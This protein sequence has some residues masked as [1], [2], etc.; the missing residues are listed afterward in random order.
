M[1]KHSAKKTQEIMT[2]VLEEVNKI[3]EKKL[4]GL[5]VVSVKLQPAAASK[6]TLAAND[7]GCTFQLVCKPIPGGMDCK[8][9]CV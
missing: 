4:P 5:S 6:K 7:N 1:P 3:L 2:G 9:K 8:V